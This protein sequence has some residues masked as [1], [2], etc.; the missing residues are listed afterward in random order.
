MVVVFAQVVDVRVIQPAAN[1]SGS[2]PWGGAFGRRAGSYTA[3]VFPGLG[4]PDEHDG[5]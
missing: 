3:R 4:Q 5:V 1:D 2:N